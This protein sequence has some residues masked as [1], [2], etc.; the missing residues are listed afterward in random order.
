MLL[1]SIW[2]NNSC[3]KNRTVKKKNDLGKKSIQIFNMRLGIPL[4]LLGFAR[5]QWINIH[6]THVCAIFFCWHHGLCRHDVTISPCW[7]SLSSKP[8][9]K[10]KFR[11]K[12][13]FFQVST[14]SVDH[15][16]KIEQFDKP[17]GP[18]IRLIHSQ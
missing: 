4:L 17:R 7:H 12:I 8:L 16:H 10:K 18:Q 3:Q 1:F 15:K 13:F 2:K 6:K 14:S 11:K 9:K 5:H